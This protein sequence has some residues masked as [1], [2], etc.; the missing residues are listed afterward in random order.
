MVYLEIKEKAFVPMRDEGIKKAKELV[1]EEDYTD[2]ITL[3]DSLIYSTEPEIEFDS[4]DGTIR[5]SASLMGSLE[6]GN[7]EL[8]YIS[9][10]ISLDLDTVTEIVQYYMKKL[11]KI[12]TVLEATK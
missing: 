3:D 5:Y 1:G 2:E 8:G 12:K 4:T 11:G 10:S 6:K 9:E 7:I